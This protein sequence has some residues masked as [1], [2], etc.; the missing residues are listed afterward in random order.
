MREL[1]REFVVGRQAQ[2]DARDRAMSLAW[3]IAAFS[4]TERLPKLDAVLTPR[5]VVQS[6]PEQR[7]ALQVLAAQYGIPLR[8]VAQHG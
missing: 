6:L 3:H 8:T 5:R 1:F 7:A 4:R 2:Q